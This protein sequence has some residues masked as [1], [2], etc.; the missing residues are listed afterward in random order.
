M[1]IYLQRNSLL[2]RITLNVIKLS[3]YTL[4]MEN[5]G[6]DLSPYPPSPPLLSLLILLGLFFVIERWGCQDNG[7]RIDW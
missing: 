7:Y 4:L 6:K 5:R 1:A 3:T 2:R